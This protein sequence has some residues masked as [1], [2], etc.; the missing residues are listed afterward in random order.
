MG[1]ADGVWR[2]EPRTGCLLVRTG[3]TGLGA[4]AGHDLTI[5]VTRWACLVTVDG[6]D[7]ARSTVSVDVEADSLEVRE[8][9]GG[10]KP[11]TGSDRA[12]IE[13]AIRGKILHTARHPAITFR[14]TGV[15]GPPDS[16]TVDGDLTIMDRT[17]PVTVRGTLDEDG[18]VRATA[19]VRQTRWG[20]KPYSAFFG[21][22]K[23]ADE[24]A[25]EVD[26]LLSPQG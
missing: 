9:T 7:P 5:E 21:A 1:L 14:S 8:G 22:L 11:L 24:V 19:T 18:R 12:D 23:L 26:G 4:P 3:R 17:R 13:R 20:I 15:A 10:I 6:A 16:L 25:V 2:L